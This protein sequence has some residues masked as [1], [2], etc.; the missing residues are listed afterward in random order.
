MKPTDD[1]MELF[2]SDEQL[3]GLIAAD[4]PEDTEI[5]VLD[6]NPL[7][8]SNGRRADGHQQGQE[9]PGEES[10]VPSGAPTRPGEV[11]ICTGGS[12]SASLEQHSVG[13]KQKDASCL[14]VWAESAHPRPVP[15]GETVAKHFL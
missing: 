5:L 13:A 2:E 14:P 9:N 11:N 6:A 15:E 1:P 3:R 10:G 7:P 12:H 8:V 4:V